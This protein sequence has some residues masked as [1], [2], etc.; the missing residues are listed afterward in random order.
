MTRVLQV[1]TQFYRSRL[2][3]WEAWALLKFNLTKTMINNARQLRCSLVGIYHQREIH[4]KRFGGRPSVGGGPGVWVSYLLNLALQFLSALKCEL[5]LP[6]LQAAEHQN[7][8]TSTHCAYLRRDG[9]AKLTWM[10]VIPSKINFPHWY[11]GVFIM[12]SRIFKCSLIHAKKSFYRSANAIFG[13]TGR[14][15][16]EH[17]TLHLICSKCIPILLYGLEACPLT[18]SD[19]SSLDFVLNRI[20]MKLFKTANIAVVD[21]CRVN[22]G[23]KLPSVLWSKRVREF[24]SKFASVDNYLSKSYV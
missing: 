1:I 10:A 21:C 2:S 14:I 13:K 5:H 11:L 12:R 18:K 15:A 8:L 24:N 17:V 23:L 7:A 19:L 6:L 4:L 16:S 9:Q 3:W 22:F 20:M